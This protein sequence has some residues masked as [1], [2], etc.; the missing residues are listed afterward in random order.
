MTYQYR[1]PFFYG[2][3]FRTPACRGNRSFGAILQ[4]TAGSPRTA[5]ARRT[6]AG[7]LAAGLLVCSLLGGCASGLSA[8]A[9]GAG[10]ADGSGAAAGGAA[11][12]SGGAGPVN[13]AVCNKP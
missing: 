3:P 1:M 5:P 12:A 9:G 6:L 10:S 7:L 4:T 2:R 13:V 11:D 8:A